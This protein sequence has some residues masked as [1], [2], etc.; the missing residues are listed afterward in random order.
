MLDNSILKTL[1]KG[2]GG[3]AYK[4]AKELVDSGYHILDD[5]FLKSNYVTR[6]EFEVLQAQVMKLCNE[7]STIKKKD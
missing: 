2:L 4:A 1:V 3:N 5:K 6:E 7:I